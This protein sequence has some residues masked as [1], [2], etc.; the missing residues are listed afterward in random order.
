MTSDN[1][2]KA[3][4]EYLKAIHEL[5]EY[6]QQGNKTI[7]ELNHRIKALESER[8]QIAGAQSKAARDYWIKWAFEKAKET[9]LDMNTYESAEQVIQ[10]LD[11]GQDNGN[12]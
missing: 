1:D 11:K 2:K 6:V 8:E 5:Q 12:V 4:K 10:E 3:A 9:W 7:G